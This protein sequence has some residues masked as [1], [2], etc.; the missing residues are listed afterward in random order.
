MRD[1]LY[2]PPYPFR[3]PRPEIG[4]APA[5]VRYGRE[6][7]VVM[8]V[9]ADEIERVVLLRN[10][11]ETHAVDGDQRGV[12]LRVLSRRGRVLRL[13][14]PPSGNVAPP[15]PYLLFANRAG[16]DGPVPSVGRAVTVG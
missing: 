16:E 7:T 14:A 11:S 9:P 13:A 4:S 15:G 12:Q 2:S 6:L 5:R 3:G 8:D 10:G 1:S